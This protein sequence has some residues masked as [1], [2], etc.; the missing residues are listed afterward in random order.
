MSVQSHPQASEKEKFHGNSNLHD[1]RPVS[2]RT[3]TI[4]RVSRSLCS[5]NCFSET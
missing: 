4:C 1:I 3:K 2:T 5:K